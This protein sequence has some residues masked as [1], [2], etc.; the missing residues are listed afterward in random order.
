[1]G[2]VFP[3]QNMKENH[4]KNKDFSSQVKTPNP[5]ERRDKLWEAPDTF[6]FLRH[7][8]RAIW[9]VWAKCSHRLLNLCKSSSTRPFT[10]PSKPLWER[11]GLNISR[12]KLFRS[13]SYKRSKQQAIPCRRKK[14]ETP[15]S[16][17]M[18]I[19]ALVAPYCAIPR[20]YLSDS[21]IIPPYCALWGFWC[22]HI[23]NWMRYP[24]PL[25]WAFPPW[26]ACEV[27]VRYPPTKRV[28][29]RYLRDTICYKAKGCDTRLCDTIS[30]RYCA[31]WGGYLALRRQDQGLASLDLLGSSS[32]VML[33]VFLEESD[34]PPTRNYYFR[35]V[36][37]GGLFYLRLGLFCL[38]L[39]F[40]TYGGLF[41]L[42]SK[43]GLVF[44]TYSG[45]LVW[46]FL[47][48]VENRFGLFFLRFLLSRKLGLV[49][50]TYGSP[51]VSK[52]DE[53]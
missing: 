35:K 3:L 26:R 32:L 27:E 16:K 51:T 37:R 7:V 17:E 42:R 38:R 19:R 9:S 49:F 1:M 21:I 29:Q 22:L 4:Q 52:K 39:V 33:R 46:S 43:F 30:K 15:K 48:T 6:N 40:V 36:K 5:W 50:F 8:M 53:P 45:N 11:N 14:Q 31:I 10:Q 44:F 13:I 12:F 18:K 24:L 23:A 47:L 28:S 34:C 20:D 2:E 41:C 25:F